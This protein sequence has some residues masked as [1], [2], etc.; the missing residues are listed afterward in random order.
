MPAKL[1]RP[2]D[3][4]SPDGTPIEHLFPIN[5]AIAKMLRG[6]GIVTVEF[7][8][9]LTPHAVAFLGGAAQSWVNRAKRYVESTKKGK[10]PLW[11]TIEAIS[12]EHRQ[13]LDELVDEERQ[14]GWNAAVEEIA[15]GLELENDHRA[16][17]AARVR[18]LKNLKLK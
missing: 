2:R 14:Y 10:P 15:Q 12:K 9:R 16:A 18:Q 3:G 13:E 6:H 4:A 17:R 8:S 1:K 11:R 5:P 7:C